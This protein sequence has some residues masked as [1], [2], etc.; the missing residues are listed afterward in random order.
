MNE[1][2][3]EDHFFH[4]F[5]ELKVSL[6]SVDEIPLFLQIVVHSQVSYCNI[7]SW[8]DWDVNY[9][10]LQ[11]C[12]YPTEGTLRLI[13][14]TFNRK[15]RTFQV[16]IV[17]ILNIC[18]RYCLLPQTVYF[19]I[20]VVISSTYF[21]LSSFSHENSRHSQESTRSESV[22]CHKIPIYTLNKPN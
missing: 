5:P 14:T 15:I 21:E 1:V 11:Y 7:E 13:L 2:R 17:G 3:F 10:L 6:S 16:I 4:F 22:L 18:R 9:I 12:T 20:F 19:V 8:L